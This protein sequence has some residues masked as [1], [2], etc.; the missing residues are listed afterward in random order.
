MTTGIALRSNYFDLVAKTNLQQPKRI[1]G[2]EDTLKSNLL[3]SLAME[4][5]GSLAAPLETSSFY[6]DS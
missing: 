6:V 1:D 5:G 4:R 2:R 3:V